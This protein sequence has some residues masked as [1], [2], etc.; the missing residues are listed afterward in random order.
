[1]REIQVAA[2]DVVLFVRS[3]STMTRASVMLTP[4]PMNRAQENR[5]GEADGGTI[6]SVE[7]ATM[8]IP[9]ET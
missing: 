9:F 4:K 8:K 5:I 7:G 1:M 6:D 3:S 2:V